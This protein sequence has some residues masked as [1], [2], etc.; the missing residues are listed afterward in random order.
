MLVQIG[1]SNKCGSVRNDQI[2]NLHT[3]GMWCCSICF[4]ES[5]VKVIKNAF[6]LI[7]KAL[8]VVNIF[9]SLCQLFGD[10]LSLHEI[11]YVSL[12]GTLQTVD[13]S[14]FLHC[15]LLQCCSI[16]HKYNI[17]FIFEAFLLP[18]QD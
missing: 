8:F 9:T 10:F 1:Q 5:P 16:N 2:F 4:N 3:L 14:N 6:Y 11:C 15:H 17:V 18:L 7:L 12:L 13:I